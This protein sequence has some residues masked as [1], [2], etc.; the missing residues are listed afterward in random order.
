L[1]GYVKNVGGKEMENPT[2]EELRIANKVWDK[3]FGQV[4]DVES[5]DWT[6]KRE[7]IHYKVKKSGGDEWTCNCK[8]WIFKSATK[9]VEDLESGKTY[10]RTCKHIRFCMKNEGMKLRLRGW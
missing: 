2:R 5:M 8:S 10:K 3:V 7:G 6:R 9:T 4:F 1:K